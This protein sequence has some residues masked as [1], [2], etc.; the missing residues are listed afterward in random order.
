LQI[1]T[2]RMQ[3]FLIKSFL[4]VTRKIN[5]NFYAKIKTGE[6]KG[7]SW[8]TEIPDSRYI[9]GSYESNLVRIDS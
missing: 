1:Y 5:L 8:N 3:E 9:I 4:K 7:Y 6:L 2:I